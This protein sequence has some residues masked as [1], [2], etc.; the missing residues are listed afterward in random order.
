MAGEEIPVNSV[1]VQIN[2]FRIKRTYDKSNVSLQKNNCIFAKTIL[3]VT[4]I[5]RELGL[6]K[7][8][9]SA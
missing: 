4:W 5:V 9:F 8:L 1:M 2:A 6:K 3:L 7:T